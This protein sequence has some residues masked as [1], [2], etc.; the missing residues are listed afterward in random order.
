MRISDWS[1]DVCSSDL[2][3]QRPSG[4]DGDGGLDVEVLGHDLLTGLGGG[5]LGRL[6]NGAHEI[7]FIEIGRASGRER[8]SGRVDLGGRRKITKKKELGSDAR[9]TRRDNN[10]IKRSRRKEEITQ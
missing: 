10:T 2:D 9:R 6:T 4:A 7:A 1:S 5:L 3:A 8:V